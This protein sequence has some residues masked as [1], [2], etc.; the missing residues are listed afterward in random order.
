M[1]T[2][3]EMLRTAREI[4]ADRDNWCQGHTATDFFG[5]EIELMDAAAHAFCMLGA[6]D[7]AQRR[8]GRDSIEA[9]QGLC[10]YLRKGCEAVGF[11]RPAGTYFI[12]DWNDHQGRKH[13]EVLAAFDHA[14]KLAETAKMEVV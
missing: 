9:F 6:A 3:A 10:G 12:D 11:H 1:P 8:A 2:T 7:L 14:I 13:A 4:I 5:N